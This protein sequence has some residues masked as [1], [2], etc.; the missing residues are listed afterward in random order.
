M[1]EP[2]LF[3]QLPPFFQL[4]MQKAYDIVLTE[5]QPLATETTTQ[6]IE[7]FERHAKDL[8]LRQWWHVVLALPGRMIGALILIVAGV[9]ASPTLIGVGK[10]FVE[11][12][13]FAGD[14][15]TACCNYTRGGT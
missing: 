13:Q 1:S 8:S 5:R 14:S 10:G 4:L 6:L 2:G 11:S 12:P 15:H 3:D 9:A 7:G